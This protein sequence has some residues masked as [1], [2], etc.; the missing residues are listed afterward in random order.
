MERIERN[1]GFDTERVKV[2]LVQ[3]GVS[4]RDRPH[5][6]TLAII[7]E[8]VELRGQGKSRRSLGHRYGVSS[9]SIRDAVLKHQPGGA[10]DM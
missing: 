4:M 9:T 2:K 1:T 10:A 5:K 8:A 6:L 3:S 7:A